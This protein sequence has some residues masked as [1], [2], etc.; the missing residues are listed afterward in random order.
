M[1]VTGFSAPYQLRSN[2]GARPTV[3]DAAEKLRT[4]QREW[5]QRVLIEKG[6]KP[7]P[8][9]KTLG[10]AA[11]TLTR[12]LNDPDDTA[13]LS[14]LIVRRIADHLKVQ[15][16]NFLDDDLPAVHSRRGFA[17]TDAT[18]YLP[19]PG[20]DGD[21]I[22]IIH[23]MT[24]RP[25]VDPWRMRGRAL[26]CMAYLPGDIMLV[27]LNAEAQPGDIVCAQVYDWTDH[28]NSRTVFRVYTPPFLVAAGPGEAYR[29]PFLVD[30]S[31][32]VIKGVV[33]ASL[34]PRPRASA[35]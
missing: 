22:Q 9:A 30:N 21:L 31:N 1:L 23:R 28:S 35:A 6:I 16:P 3:R 11:T 26:E 12:K 15:V 29:A 8:L 18:P 27:D 20:L 5:L 14:D 24:D 7:T 25:G 33:I 17:E 34:R 4:R 10:V 32:V 13:I 2:L 19:E